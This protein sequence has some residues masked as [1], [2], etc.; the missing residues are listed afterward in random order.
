MSMPMSLKCTASKSNE[1]EGRA[2]ISVKYL[3][4][5]VKRIS[6][7]EVMRVVEVVTETHITPG[8]LGVTFRGEVPVLDVVP[9][10]TGPGGETHD[11]WSHRGRTG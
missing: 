2:A 8:A 9:M 1:V 11:L 4:R 5:S 10:S 3:K 7:H 6:A